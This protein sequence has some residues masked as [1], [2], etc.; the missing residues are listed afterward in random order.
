MNSQSERRN[1]SSHKDSN[2]GYNA[3]LPWLQSLPWQPLSNIE[4]PYNYK[5]L[6]RAVYYEGGRISSSNSSSRLDSPS[7][8]KK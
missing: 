7:E 5:K 2:H 4:L 3:W 8:K 1:K 6:K